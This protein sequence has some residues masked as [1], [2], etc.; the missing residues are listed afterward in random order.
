ME[1]FGN[2]VFGHPVFGHGLK[3]SLLGKLGNCKMMKRARILFSGSQY[4]ANTWGH[5]VSHLTNAQID[6]LEKRAAMATG[7]HEA[8]RCRSLA[9]V[10]GYGPRG[11]PIARILKELFTEWFRVLR[12]ISKL[13]Y[14]AWQNLVI[15]WGIARANLANK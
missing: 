15:A 10:V 7:I 3:V 11:H 13:G 4:S 2:P 1:A 5:Q 14:Y 6:S 12:N 9:L 8:G